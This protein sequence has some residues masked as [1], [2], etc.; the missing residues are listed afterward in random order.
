[1]STPTEPTPNIQHELRETAVLITEYGEGN[2]LTLADIAADLPGGELTLARLT[3]GDFADLDLDKLAPAY[4]ARRQSL[5]TETG[6]DTLYEDLSP[7]LAVRG[8]FSQLKLSVTKAKLVIVEGVTGSGKTSAGEIIARKFNGLSTTQQVYTIEA[9]AGWGDRPNAMM[10]AMLKALGRPDSSRNQAARLDKL[11]D[12]LNERPVVFIVDEVHDFGVRCL[13]VV[14]TLLNLSKV[15][16]VMLCHPRLFKDLER[17]NWDDLSQLT[18]NRLLA[19]ISLGSVSINDVTL[20][21]QRRLISPGLN[22]DLKNAAKIIAESALNNG[23]LAFVRE[24]IGRLNK[25]AAKKPGAH[26]TT[27]DV[28]TAVKTELRAR[29][30]ASTASL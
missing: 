28:T 24:T 14:K 16:I 2:G 7:A 12:V 22:G 29:S 10:S 4:R 26:L 27:E 20:L 21:L 13:R 5:A 6:H 19:R 25:A 30:K 18:G 17:E 3:I 1:M 23:N 15:K 9:S 8:R 11:A